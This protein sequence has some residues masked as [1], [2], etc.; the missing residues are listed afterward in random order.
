MK[1]RD[2]KEFLEL[3]NKLYSNKYNY[4]KVT[5]KNNYTK[6]TI[7]C[8]AHGE[9][10]QTPLQH[11]RGNGCT[12]CNKEE[13]KNYQANSFL[14]RANIMHNQKYTYDISNYSN[15]R[16]NITI[17]CPLHGDFLQIPSNHLKGH[18]C[19]ECQY[20][21]ITSINSK[22]QDNFI[23][24]A[25]KIHSDAYDYSKVVYKNTNTKITIVCALHGP[26]KQTP[27]HHL[28]GC[29]CPKCA[30][31]GFNPSKIGYL[32]YLSI[33]NG[34]AY[35]IGITNKSVNERF[36]ITDLRNIKVLSLWE[37]TEG[38]ECYDA[39]QKILAKFKEFQYK[40]PKLLASG[41]TELFSI[42]VYKQ[43]K[44]QIDEINT[45]GKLQIT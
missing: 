27:T 32:Y 19:Q 41:N 21:L 13:R 26:F 29:G 34:E 43:Y 45:K 37:F 11:L 35:K 14:T 24:D 1:T 18:G 16:T 20:E 5:Y 4:T 2:Q 8:P 3:A 17:T 38:S 39:E 15:N 28:R 6:V 44:E 25:K 9:F 10:E 33:N 40:G 30:E 31:Y 22:T 23:K 7:I 12:D 36:T 42:D